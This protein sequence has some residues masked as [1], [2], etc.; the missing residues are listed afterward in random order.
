MC[1]NDALN[2]AIHKANTYSEES[3][4]WKKD[5]ALAM[6]YYDFRNLLESGIEIFD[7]ITKIDEDCRLQ[8]LQGKLPYDQDVAE[9]ISNVYRLL[10]AAYERIVPLLPF[11]ENEFGAVTGAAEFLRR[12]QEAKGIVTPDDK[13][14]VGD[15]LA[16]LCDTAIDENRNGEAFNVGGTR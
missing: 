10:V 7:S 8:I 12:Y 6:V 3:E 15:A 2:L 1:V 5:H 11:F 13:F 14:F 16:R 4:L 9:R